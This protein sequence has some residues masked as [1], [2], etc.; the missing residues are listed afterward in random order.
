M[1]KKQ[2]DLP[3]G[4]KAY[5]WD[6]YKITF[7][8]NGTLHVEMGLW[9]SLAAKTAGNTPVET[10]SYGWDSGQ[11]SIKLAGQLNSIKNLVKNIPEFSDAVDE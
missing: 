11:H 4:V 9:L 5:H 1:L 7:T 6:I 2:K 3:T 10:R 8:Q